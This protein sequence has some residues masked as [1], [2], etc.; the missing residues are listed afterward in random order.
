MTP[1]RLLIADDEPLI[2]AGIR[3]ILE[4][5]PGIEIAAECANGE[6]TVAAIRR[7]PLDLVLLDIQMPDC[8]GVDVI[9][10]I[11]VEKMPPVVFVTAF[12]EYAIRAFEL[13]AVDYVLKPFDEERLLRSLGRARER[14]GA[15]DREQ[16]SR[17]LRSLLEEAEQK[18]PERLV[19]RS[20]DGYDMVPVKSVDW[21]EAADNYVEL[22][23]GSRVHLLN[24]SMS[25]LER[26]LDR[27]QFVRVHRGRIVNISRITRI[28]PLANGS[29]ELRLQDGARLTTGKQY[30]NVVQGLLS[31][32][33]Q[34]R[35]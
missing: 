4:G 19:V 7:Q 32:K 35:G 10:Q 22:H 33:S 6:E 16:L 24:D 30:L 3:A 13:N 17:Q 2:R 27:R 14:A 21:V 9:R 29:Y 1:L 28:A 18:G 25:N 20:R 8:S 34:N 11:G 23:C 26:Q 31:N 5:A 15:R 12:D